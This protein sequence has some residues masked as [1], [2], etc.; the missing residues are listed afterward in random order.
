MV[1]WL[2]LH[3]STAGGGGGSVPG[4][5]DLGY[6]MLCREAKKRMIYYFTLLMDGYNKKKKRKKT[7][8]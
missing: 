8:I 7:K 3:A 4:L 1:Q 5:G 2:S 6:I